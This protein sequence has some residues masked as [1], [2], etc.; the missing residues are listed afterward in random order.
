MTAP[1]GI[2]ANNS[3]N[4]Q[5]PSIGPPKFS[6][7]ICGNSARGMPKIMAMRSTTNDTIRI[8]CAPR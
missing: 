5:P 8:L 2:D 1:A 6:W 7:A 3:A 4:A